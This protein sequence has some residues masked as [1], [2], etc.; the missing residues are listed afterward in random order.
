LTPAPHTAFVGLGANLGDPVATLRQAIA[1]LAGLPQTQ[2]AAASA[3]Y[4]SAPIGH[5]DQPDF[6]NAVAQLATGLA[7]QALL[8]ALLVLEKRHGRER[9][10]RNAPRTLDLDLLLYDAL[11][12]AEAGLRLPHPRMH[13]RAFVLVPLLEI[14]PACLIPGIGLAADALA[15]LS[16]QA[17]EKLAP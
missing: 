1:A 5:G 15:R 16:G 9:S 10:F 14:T 7:P 17:V 13:E 8:A 11:Q 4:R 6:V 2:L 12:M 3:L